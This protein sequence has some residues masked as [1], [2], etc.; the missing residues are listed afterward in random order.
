M[1][2]QDLSCHTTVQQQEWQSL[3]NFN[4]LSNHFQNFGSFCFWPLFAVFYFHRVAAVHLT[5]KACVAK[6]WPFAL[7]SSEAWSQKL[8]AEPKT[9]L[10]SQLL[11]LL[12]LFISEKQ[13]V[14]NSL[15]QR[16]F[17]LSTGAL[18]GI[19]CGYVMPSCFFVCGGN[20][21]N[22]TK[23]R[24]GAGDAEAMRENSNPFHWWTFR[25]PFEELWILAS[26]R[27]GRFRVHDKSPRASWGDN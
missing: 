15:F 9:S 2:L 22:C 10:N 19:E 1:N 8:D 4:E 13:G 12:K 3:F 21:Q 20:H 18:W 17:A 7:L 14:V 23:P 11:L 27:F 5:S 26:E 25:T 24:V 6:E 16:C